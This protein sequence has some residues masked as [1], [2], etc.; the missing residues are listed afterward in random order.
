MET[1]QDDKVG[2]KAWGGTVQSFNSVL[3][4]LKNNLDEIHRESGKYAGSV[5]VYGYEYGYGY[6]Y[7]SKLGAIG[8]Y[9]MCGVS[10]ML[11]DYFHTHHN[12][13]CTRV[14]I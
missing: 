6:G 4:V 5:C 7:V 14:R 3:E 13:P 10:C 12:H 8:M 9:G 1:V 11:S 2:S